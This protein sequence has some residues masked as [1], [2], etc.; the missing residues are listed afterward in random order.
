MTKV[1]KIITVIVFGIFLLG[2][3]N[4]DPVVPPTIKS[5]LYQFNFEG[6]NST[7]FLNGLD[8]NEF[9]TTDTVNPANKVLKCVLPNGVYRSEAS[10]GPGSPHYFYAD[11]NDAAHGDEFWIGIR[12]FKL[13]EKYT[14]S[15]ASPSIFQIGPVQ[16]LVTYPGVTSAGLYQLQLNTST[17]KWKWREFSSVFNSNS[18]NTDISPV[19]YGK[20]DRFVFHCR[21]RSNSTGLIE[22]WQNDVLIYSLSRQNAI[23]NDRAFIK[24]GVYLGAGNTVHEPLSC[25]FDDV[26]VGGSGSNYQEVVPK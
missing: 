1:F 19:N 5:L 25:Y 21:F 3:K 4:T 6:N 26:K 20:W 8:G 12:I 16:N 9:V 24:W 10:V 17:N 7:D 14:G 18:T 11:T 13:L 2:C 22:V 15:N 23:K